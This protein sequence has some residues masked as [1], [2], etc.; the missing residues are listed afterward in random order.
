MFASVT[1][2]VF[3]MLSILDSCACIYQA[4]KA[5]RPVTASATDPAVDRSQQGEQPVPAPQITTSIS[6]TIP[7]TTAVTTTAH[8][9]AST[10]Q[11]MAPTSTAALRILTAH[12]KVECT[13]MRVRRLQQLPA[14][15][16]AAKKAD[17][18]VRG[19]VG[20]WFGAHVGG[21][22]AACGGTVVGILV[23]ASSHMKYESDTNA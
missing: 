18:E 23:N 1:S 8:T 12:T 16:G 21:S 22:A 9:T 19:S 13:V 5:T 15:E 11:H 3:L 20:C 14:G 17:L 6:T 10:A 4:G 7:S 2:N